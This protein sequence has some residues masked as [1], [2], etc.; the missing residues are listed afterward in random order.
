MS[1]SSTTTH[2]K[3]REDIEL[4]KEDVELN[5][6]GPSPIIYAI[7]R[8]DALSKVSLPAARRGRRKRAMFSM[9]GIRSCPSIQSQ[10][11]YVIAP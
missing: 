6:D 7:D 1:A 5:K 9:P 4:E 10:K 11:S 2:A 3:S 8:I